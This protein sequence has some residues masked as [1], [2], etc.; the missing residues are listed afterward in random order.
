[1]NQTI[2]IS[3]RMIICTKVMKESYSTHPNLELDEISAAT[4]ISCQEI[5][6]DYVND[7]EFVKRLSELAVHISKLTTTGKFTLIFNTELDSA[8]KNLFEEY[9]LGDSSYDL[10]PDL[11]L[12][13][14]I[15]SPED[16]YWIEVN[17][18]PNLSL[19]DIELIKKTRD[20]E[21]LSM[22]NAVSE[23][24]NMNLLDLNNETIMGNV[25]DNKVSSKSANP[26]AKSAHS[27]LYSKCSNDVCIRT[28]R[29]S[30]DIFDMTSQQI[31]ST[32]IIPTPSNYLG[33]G[34]KI[35]TSQCLDLM[36]LIWG[37]AMH[38]PINPMTGE[39]FNE[40]VENSL[41]GRYNKEIRMYKRYLE[42]YNDIIVS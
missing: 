4:L 34:H 30:G 27:N 38:P 18:N 33:E 6:K 24:M 42:F 2:V 8:I 32:V 39:R 25:C 28:E 37:L 29:K 9:P 22:I 21:L 40:H 10:D 5:M 3:N 14:L 31:P 17:N 41:I 36:T 23:A 11:V 1:M 16:R 7:D 12:R 20:Q 35:T 15:R 13:A 26:S 19:N